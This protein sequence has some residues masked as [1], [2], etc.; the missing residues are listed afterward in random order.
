MFVSA[1]LRLRSDSRLESVM[2]RV[3]EVVE[4]IRERLRGRRAQPVPVKVRR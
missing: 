4:E 3:R 1:I 2:E